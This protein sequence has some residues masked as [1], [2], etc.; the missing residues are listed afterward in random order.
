[1]SNVRNIGDN[2]P[3]HDRHIL[4]TFPCQNQKAEPSPLDN[5]G[6][7][8]KNNPIF[9]TAS[10][11]SKNREQ[12]KECIAVYQEFKAVSQKSKAVCQESEAVCQEFKAVY[13]QLNP[14]I[15]EGIRQ[16]NISLNQ[17][18]NNLDKKAAKRA[19]SQYINS[20]LAGYLLQ[21]RK[22]SVLLKG[23]G[24]TL[25]ECSSTLQHN[26]NGEVTAVRYCKQRWCP[27]CE[28]IRMNLQSKKLYSAI[29]NEVE[30]TG[31]EPYLVT[32]TLQNVLADK[33]KY[34]TRLNWIKKILTRIF[35]NN[36]VRK[37]NGKIDDLIKGF[38]SVET[39]YNPKCFFKNGPYQ[40]ESYETYHPHVHLVVFGY[41]NAQWILAQWRKLIA[42]EADKITGIENSKDWIININSQDIRPI[43][44]QDAKQLLELC[45]YSVKGS[46]WKQDKK[47]GKFYESL[48]PA[49]VRA[50]L[51]EAHY[52]LTLFKCFG[53]FKMTSTNEEFENEAKNEQPQFEMMVDEETGEVIEVEVENGSE[54]AFDEKELKSETSLPNYTGKTI[55][56]KWDF[57]TKKY[58][59]EWNSEVYHIPLSSCFDE[60]IIKRYNLKKKD[61]I[62]IDMDYSKFNLFRKRPIE[63]GWFEGITKIEETYPEELMQYIYDLF[64]LPIIEE[65]EEDE[66]PK[67]A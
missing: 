64:K 26:Q 41:E 39:T 21:H 23:L 16:G 30:Q 36:R 2:P 27:I 47:T 54:D 7:S 53:N 29:K 55:V 13:P 67:F 59:P 37:N 57:A 46:S 66:E 62:E 40:G 12:A 10:P 45:K 56:W 35:H 6:R 50:D 48:Y 22:G 31:Q 51:Y 42:K 9:L 19:R 28:S 18:L 43:Q 25:C 24:N 49:H 17:G 8:V 60:Y 44:Y 1:M 52:G 5:L 65:K 34:I 3:N 61:T 11:K 33:E 15:L 38:Y 63:E 32:L 20:Q 4:S 14:E 58:Y